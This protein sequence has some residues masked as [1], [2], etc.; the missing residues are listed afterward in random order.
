MPLGGLYSRGKTETMNEDYI[1][2][3]TKHTYINNINEILY[4]I[5][6]SLYKTTDKMLHMLC[7]FISL[8]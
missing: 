3:H 5:V 7:V 4:K 6:Y 2:I 8:V 1:Y